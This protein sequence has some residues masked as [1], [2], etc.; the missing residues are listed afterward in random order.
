LSNG[1]RKLLDEEPTTNDLDSD[2]TYAYSN[3]AYT[4]DESNSYT[5]EQLQK[6]YPKGVY[7]I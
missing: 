1:Y 6:D 3:P 4:L 5:L 2:I 7:V